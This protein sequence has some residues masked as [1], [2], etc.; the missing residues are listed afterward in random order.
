MSPLDARRQ[1]PDEAAARHHVI[2][3]RRCL[4]SYR[5]HAAS[6]L[7]GGSALENRGRPA[8]GA[9]R[10]APRSKTCSEMHSGGTGR[11]RRFNSGAAAASSNYRLLLLDTITVSAPAPARV[12][13]TTTTSVS[14]AATATGMS[15]ATAAVRCRCVRCAGMTR[16]GTR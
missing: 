9:R 12:S 8:G 5:L 2:L 10:S 14:A 13:A 11:F 16:I 4:Y 15:A 1:R 6:I 7:N 3:R